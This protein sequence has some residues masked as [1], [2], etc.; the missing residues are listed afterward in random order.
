MYLQ[1]SYVANDGSKF[2]CEFDCL[3]HEAKLDG[4]T[5]LC[6]VC[7]GSRTEK[8][9]PVIKAMDAY[10]NRLVGYEQIPCKVCDGV[11][12]T[13]KEKTP[14]TKTKIVGWT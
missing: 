10:T 6:P 7:K 14:I 5:F 4:N 9:K 3:Q 2:D 12:W 13:E 11:G 8:G 1:T